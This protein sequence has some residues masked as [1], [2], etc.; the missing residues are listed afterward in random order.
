MIMIV[1]IFSCEIIRITGSSR[2]KGKFFLFIAE[3]SMSMHIVLR[4][5]KI[6]FPSIKC[7]QGWTIGV[8]S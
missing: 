3:K 4:K 5:E 6:F 1:I 8:V 7:E 2:K